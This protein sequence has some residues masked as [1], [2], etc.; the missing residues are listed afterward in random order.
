[1]YIQGEP[2]KPAATLLLV[3]GLGLEEFIPS[4]ETSGYFPK[5]P[6]EKSDSRTESGRFMSHIG[7]KQKHGNA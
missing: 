1:M 7:P 4:K 2:S 3:G 6:K 5:D